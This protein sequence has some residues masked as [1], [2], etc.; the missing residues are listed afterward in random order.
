MTNSNHDDEWSIFAQV[1]EDTK[2]WVKLSVKG[3]LGSLGRVHCLA[4]QAC[5]HAIH[6]M[7]R[8]THT[9]LTL[10]LREKTGLY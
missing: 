7:T 3:I 4:F 10:C 9:V 1:T 5:L 6:G 8:G 2:L